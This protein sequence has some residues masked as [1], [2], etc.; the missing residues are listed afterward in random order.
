MIHYD[1]FYESHSGFV[2]HHRFWTRKGGRSFSLNQYQNLAGGHGVARRDTDLLH[3]TGGDSAQLV[4]HLHR[5]DP[6]LWQVLA[7]LGQDRSGAERLR[8]V[9]HAPGLERL[10]LVPA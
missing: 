2:K 3:L 1:S 7:D 6:R 4:L 9:S 8:D 10:V 5:P